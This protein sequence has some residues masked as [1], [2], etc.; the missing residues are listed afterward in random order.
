MTTQPER[1]ARRA[2][3]AETMPAEEAAAPPALRVVEGTA[4]TGRDLRVARRIAMR[5]GIQVETDA[6]AVEALEAK[7]IDPFDRGALMAEFSVSPD[8][9]IV[10]APRDV[11]PGAPSGLRGLERDADGRGEAVDAIRGDIAA[12]RRVRVRRL[13]RRLACYV[14]A[15]TVCAFLWYAL[16][17][18]PLYETKTEFVIQQAE[19]AAGGSG[20][21]GLFAGT[22]LA[23]QQDSIAVQGY[24]T[25]RE[26]FHRLDADQGFRAH[27]GGGGIDPLRQL[28]DGDTDEDAYALYR[29]MV[30]IGYDPTEGVVR[31]AVSAADPATSQGFAE[32]L[33]GYAEEQVDQLTGRL[34]GDQMD[35]AQASFE[36]AEA[37]MLDAQRRVVDLQERLG[38]VSADA[39]LSNA[40]GQISAVETALRE[41][42][43]ELDA[44]MDNRR[45]NATR[46]DVATRRVVQLEAELAGLRDGLTDA[47]ADADSLARVTAEL[48]VAQVDLQ[49][50]Q[51]L[52]QQAAQQLEVSRIEANRQVRYLS[53]PVP[54][55]A[56]DTAT[57][58]A[59]WAKTGLAALIFGGIYLMVSLTAAILREQV[60]A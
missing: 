11:T 51:L 30:E 39:E 37:K 40:Y 24:L 14:A 44:L 4:A 46:V 60:S 27:F 13:A 3:R 54:P 33:L 32:A 43:L 1:A 20:L 10:T 56:P 59:V 36:E 16:F 21:G 29:D 49:T 15:P 28:D 26:A 45:P 9:P 47:G 17:A 12:R 23:S 48:G 41:E 5:H 25:S 58:P 42:R 50:R 35:G 2:A 31:M 18:T 57:Y 52:L 7:G 34:R 55:V 53:T 22:G 19:P 8:A 6:E 38:V